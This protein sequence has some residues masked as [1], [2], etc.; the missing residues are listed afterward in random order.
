MTESH[1]HR[2]ACAQAH[3]VIRNQ[4][5]GTPLSSGGSSS[6]SSVPGTPARVM[7]DQRDEIRAL[8]QVGS[9]QGGQ[10]GE[11]VVDRAGT[12]LIQILVVLYT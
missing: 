8:T 6:S 11:K 7:R 4:S 5:G 2:R 3:V 1:R 10:E 12:K 9:G